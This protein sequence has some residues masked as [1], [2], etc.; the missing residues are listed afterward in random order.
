M[1]VIRVPYE[2][3]KYKGQLDPIVAYYLTRKYFKPGQTIIDPMAG[4]KTIEQAATSL[5][6]KCYSNDLYYPDGW[7]ATKPKWMT[8][9][10]GLIAASELDGVI[11]HVPYFKAKIYGTKPED[12]GNTVDYNRF[13]HQCTEVLR[14]A[15]RVTR[16]DGYIIFIIGD[17]RSK[18]R[19]YPTSSYIIDRAE[20]QLTLYLE[21]Y[22]LWELSATG[23]PFTSTKHMMMINWCLA[24]KVSKQVT[25]DQKLE[26]KSCISI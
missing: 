10:G 4:A 6:V 18:G 15:Q 3:R 13:L 12:L 25:L 21:N 7:D 1:S 9:N 2:P 26:S 11:V 19:I 5:G 8:P 20:Q 16:H 22:D 14:H 23:T 17:Y 24:F